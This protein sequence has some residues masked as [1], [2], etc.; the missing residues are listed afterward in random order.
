MTGQLTQT[1][2]PPA[3][4]TVRPP[5]PSVRRH[6]FEWHA[7]VYQAPSVIVLAAVVLFPLAYSVNLSLR[8]Y[9][10]VIPGRTGQFVGAENYRRMLTD[11]N[12]GQALLTTLIFVVCAV[13]VETVLGVA[14][15]VLLD[16]LRRLSGW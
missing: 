15:G 11:V 14:A 1:V 9:S 12:F 3:G 13:T 2:E 10:L 5:A 16:R 4:S 6:R 7:V 8:A